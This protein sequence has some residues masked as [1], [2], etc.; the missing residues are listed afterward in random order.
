MS[1]AISCT[2]YRGSWDNQ[3]QRVDTTWDRLAARL[4]R[5]EE[6]NKDGP[7][8]SVATFSGIRRNENLVARSMVALDIETSG[9]TGE[10]PISFADMAAYLTARRVRAVAWSTHSHA[11]DGPRYRI[12]MPLSAPV[13]WQP[14][15]DPFLSAA[16]A[17]QLRCH[18]VSD[19]SKFG[20]ASLFFLPRHPP[21]GLHCAQLIDGD[22]IDTG[23][24]LTMATTMA[25]R[26]AQDEAE[27]AARRRANA[28]PPEILARIEAY[29]ASHPISEALAR[30]GYQREGNR[31][32]SRY[33]H[34]QGATTILA[35][36][37]AWVS[38]SASDADAGV[39]S[40]PSRASSQ[41]AAWGDSF[42]LLVHYEHRGNFRAALATLPA[43]TSM[44][45]MESTDAT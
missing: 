16:C 12:L 44:D 9:T 34:G 38:F 41:C 27:I 13:P 15:I 40:K 19:P 5:H 17:A 32:R 25:E 45:A 1:Q 7:A 29:N 21:G 35:D 10:V 28:M 20:A 30:Y 11:V 36:G 18:G 14:E 6:G 3:G 43:S 37:S 26:V 22:P 4:L 2:F 23:L 8:L 24:L 39:G 42:S 33:Q 31:W